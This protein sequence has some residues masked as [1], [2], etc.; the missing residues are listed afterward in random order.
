MS[1]TNPNQGLVNQGNFPYSV[2]RALDQDLEDWPGKLPGPLSW[3]DG[4]LQ[5]A[6]LRAKY[7]G[8]KYILYRPLLYQALHPPPLKPGDWSSRLSE[9]PTIAAAQHSSQ[10]TPPT[11][12]AYAGMNFTRHLRKMRP[13][14]GAGP[15][16]EDLNSNVR[17][18]SEIR[19]QAAINSTIAFDGIQGRLIVTNILGTTYTYVMVLSL[20]ISNNADFLL[21]RQFGNIIVL[22]AVY[23]S[24]LS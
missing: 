12:Q 10:D 21:S 7:Y 3:N 9:S 5:T 6:R 23:K 20:N 8:T 13:P 19:I 16:F 24:H 22:V 18:A 1:I 4:D 14:P 2:R 11:D 17:R 15:A